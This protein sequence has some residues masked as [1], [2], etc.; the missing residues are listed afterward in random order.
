M[1]KGYG[2]I[3]NLLVVSTFFEL[4]NNTNYELQCMLLGRLISDRCRSWGQ[5][6]IDLDLLQFSLLEQNALVSC[7]MVLLE[8][9]YYCFQWRF[10]CLL[11]VVSSLLQLPACWV[12]PYG[13]WLQKIWNLIGQELFLGAYPSYGHT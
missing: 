8:V 6:K 9:L 3:V 12:D 7:S 5:F 10:S 4:S 1:R 11:L 13:Y 2:I